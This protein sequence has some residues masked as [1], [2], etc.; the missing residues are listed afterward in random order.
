MVKKSSGSGEEEQRENEGREEGTRIM[1]WGEQGFA[2][3]D[4]QKLDP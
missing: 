2:T 3:M 1:Q 4:E